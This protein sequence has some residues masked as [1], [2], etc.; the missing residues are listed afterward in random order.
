MASVD[1]WI[2]LFHQ[3]GLKITPQR[4]VIFE[5]LAEGD[6]HPTAD[7]VYRRVTEVMPEVSRTT[8]YNTLRELIALDQ[9]TVVMEELLAEGTRY[10]TNNTHHHHLFC[11]RCH[12][13]MDIERDW[14]DVKL[15]PEKVAQ[16]QI[17]KSQV[18]FYG[19]CPDCRDR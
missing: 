12:T 17:F 19:V 6:G 4:R 13:L 16:Y 15:V 9:V 1:L 5:R 7:D 3:S 11:T 8:I 2:E 18:T 14:A 10:D